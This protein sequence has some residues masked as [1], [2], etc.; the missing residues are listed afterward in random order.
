[1]HSQHMSYIAMCQLI[2]IW[3]KM[4]ISRQCLLVSVQ[5]YS[6][7]KGC[8]THCLDIALGVSSP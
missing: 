3:V 7:L 2:D 6:K 1:M 4:V 5:Y 8:C